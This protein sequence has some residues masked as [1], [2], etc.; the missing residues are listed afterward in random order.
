MRSSWTLALVLTFPGWAHAQEKSWKGKTVILKDGV[1]V[2]F[3]QEPGGPQ[4]VL[5]HLLYITYKA[6]DDQDGKLRVSQ[7]GIEG[8][9]EK[10]KMLPIDEALDYFT[11]A[12]ANN[13]QISFF[14]SRRA[15]VYRWKG[16]HERALKDQDETI[17][18]SPLEPAYF[19]N[20][21]ISHAAKRDFD[22]A[23]EDYNEALRLKPT[24][25]LALRNRGMAWIGKKEYD[26]AI[27]DFTEAMQLEP[28][29]AAAHSGRGSALVGKKQYAA[30][31]ANFERALAIDDRLPGA[32]NDLAWLLATCPD[33]NVR[34]GPKAVE[35]ALKACAQSD[36]KAAGMIDTLA[37][38]YAEAGQFP[39]AVRYQEQAL[40][41]KA[42]ANNNE[43]RRR[44]QLY[45][46][47]KAYRG[48]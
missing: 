41:N 38:A 35:L 7:G 45:R 17:R 23:L 39:E 34:D 20:R 10:D 25:G 37:A 16:D 15:A 33:G 8:W 40:Q 48:E 14:Y 13:P 3:N 36:W 31:I 43:A 44:L 47:K 42:F 2:L 19:N 30:A 21:A 1:V 22:K 26:K 27:T 18:L 4:V 32:L 24:Y 29:D 28:R 12:I 46:E 5:G 11:A 6:L 9:V